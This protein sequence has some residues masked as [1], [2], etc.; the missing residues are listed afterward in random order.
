MK[1]WLKWIVLGLVIA[2]LVGITM[3]ILAGRK[4]KSEALDAQQAAQK[5]PAVVALA[6]TDLVLAKTA[7]VSK[8]RRR[9]IAA[10]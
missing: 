1:R 7:G 5:I 8:N 9:F 2:V 3:R 6:P 10:W 4:A